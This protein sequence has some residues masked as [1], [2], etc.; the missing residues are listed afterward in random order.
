M[1]SPS[2]YNPPEKKPSNG[3]Q[4]STQRPSYKRPT[5][6]V[7]N[8]NAPTSTEPQQA[9]YNQAPSQSYSQ[10]TTAPNNDEYGS[11]QAQEEENKR[12]KFSI[13]KK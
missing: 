9:S 6:Q 5:P 1:Q 2:A 13:V 4:R 7:S 11:A 3:Y 12:L 10:P 8:Y